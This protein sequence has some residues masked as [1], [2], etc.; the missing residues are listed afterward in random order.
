[1]SGKPQLTTLL[2]IGDATLQPPMDGIAA[3]SWAPDSKRLAVASWD[4]V[5]WPLVLGS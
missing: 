2:T 1:M 3:F 5:S 4:S